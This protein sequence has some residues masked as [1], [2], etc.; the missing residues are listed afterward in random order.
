MSLPANKLPWKPPSRAPNGR[1][2]TR[3]KRK[4]AR[5]PPCTRPCTRPRAHAH[6]RLRACT[7]AH[8]HERPKSKNPKSLNLFLKS[9][10]TRKKGTRLG[11]GQSG[12]C[13]DHIG[14]FTDM[15]HRTISPAHGDFPK[16]PSSFFRF[17]KSEIGKTISQ[18]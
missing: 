15:V 11:A 5:P 1:F 18:N 3:S 8:A 14:A 4:H 17:L 10:F 9:Q 13:L 16:E 6:A 7:R 12:S 2:N